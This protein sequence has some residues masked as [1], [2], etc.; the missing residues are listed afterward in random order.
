MAPHSSTLARESCGR[1]SLVGCCPQS[2]TESDTTEATQR[3]CLHWRIKW[4]PTPIFL[5][6]ESQGQRSLVGCRLWGHTESDMNKPTQQQQQQGSRVLTL[7]RV[8]ILQQKTLQG[9]YGRA[10]LLTSHSLIKDLSMMQMIL[11]SPLALFPC[12]ILYW[13]RVWVKMN[14]II[15][16]LNV[17]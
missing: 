5:P 2:H 9:L 17:S 14:S 12:L 16:I 3:A 7:S 1:R 11:W 13:F 15:W 4:Q 10:Y 8:L 6:G